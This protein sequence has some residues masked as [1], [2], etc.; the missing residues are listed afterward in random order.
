MTLSDPFE[1]LINDF[2]HVPLYPF[3]LR[4]RCDESGFFIFG[5]SMTLV[6]I[7][8]ADDGLKATFQPG[9]GAKKAL[10]VHFQ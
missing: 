2:I 9:R 4:P 3:N 7:D 5:A 10:L 6:L 8:R 1:F